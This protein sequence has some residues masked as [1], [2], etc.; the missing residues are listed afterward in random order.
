MKNRL[1][2]VLFGGVIVGAVMVLMTFLTDLLSLPSWLVSV[3]GLIVLVV[4]PYVMGIK[5]KKAL[6]ADVP[7]TYG[8]A[9]LYSFLMLLC[10][11]V[12][13]S[14]GSYVYLLM[15]GSEA[16]VQKSIDQLYEMGNEPTQQQIDAVT[17][18]A[19]NIPLIIGTVVFSYL[20]QSTIVALIIALF[21]R[22][23]DSEIIPNVE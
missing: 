6:P 2:D 21:I 22:K 23:K 3:L 19:T 17:V 14:I 11:S 16:L 10:A 9:F 8:K 15:Q 1:N 18:Y 7:F 13:A 20:C 5:Y 12:I 4:V